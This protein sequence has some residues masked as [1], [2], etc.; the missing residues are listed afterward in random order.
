MSFN[1]TI[2]FK[3]ICEKTYFESDW[4][5]TIKEY[6]NKFSKTSYDNNQFN[7]SFLD[8][9]ISEEIKESCEIENKI[10]MNNIL[11]INENLKLSQIIEQNKIKNYQPLIPVY[12][13]VHI[14][15]ISFTVFITDEDRSYPF[16]N[17]LEENN[18]KRACWTI[19]GNC[20]DVK[21]YYFEQE[22]EII[23][24]L[25]HQKGC[26]I[27]NCDL[28]TYKSS[29]DGTL[30]NLVNRSSLLELVIITPDNKKNSCS[31]MIPMIS[32]KNII[33]DKCI[34]NLYKIPEEF[35]NLTPIDF[36]LYYIWQIKK[37]Y[38]QWKCYKSF[39]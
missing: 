2:K 23:G 16:I 12:C 10:Y 24:Y 13:I 31:M 34:N 9:Y 22:V 11:I 18:I 21:N 39:P 27:L 3:I 6:I 36:D 5:K 29:C 20:I 8:L 30:I 4:D 38:N 14:T 19:G 15:C 35:N 7:I 17:Y 33:F 32:N 26:K 28:I 25:D 37:I 1:H